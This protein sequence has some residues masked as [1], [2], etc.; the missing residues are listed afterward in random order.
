MKFWAP[1]VETDISSGS[2]HRNEDS[3]AQGADVPCNA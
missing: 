1:S 2:R 3:D